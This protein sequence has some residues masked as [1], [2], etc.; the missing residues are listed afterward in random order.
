MSFLFQIGIMLE[1]YFPD[2]IES[3]PQVIYVTAY[4]GRESRLPVS[5]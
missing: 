2:S 5:C 3:A 4:R 1:R